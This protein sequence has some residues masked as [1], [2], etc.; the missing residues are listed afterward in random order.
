MMEIGYI[1]PKESDPM[2][3][4]FGRIVTFYLDTGFRLEPL[5]GLGNVNAPTHHIMAHTVNRSVYKI[6]AAWL[7]TVRNGENAGQQ[8]FSLT[9]DVPGIPTDIN[10][11]A[12]RNHTDNEYA[13]QWRR[14]RG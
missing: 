5:S 1:K 7:K 10:V 11:A 6:G 14:R 9:F 12:F 8:F 13:I 3:E 4:C 2:G